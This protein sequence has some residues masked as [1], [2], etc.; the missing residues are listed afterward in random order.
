MAIN[1]PR[2]HPVSALEPKYRTVVKFMA[3]DTDADFGFTDADGN[4]AL[5]YLMRNER[6]LEMKSFIQDRIQKWLCQFKNNLLNWFILVLTAY[7]DISIWHTVCPTYN[8]EKSLNFVWRSKQHRVAYNVKN[9]MNPK[10][11]HSIF[12]WQNAPRVHQQTCE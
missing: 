10:I 6:I 2:S 3:E 8:N 7:L 12:S 1:I 4:T 11:D 5:H 9:E